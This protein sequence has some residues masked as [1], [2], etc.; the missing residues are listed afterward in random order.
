MVVGTSTRVGSNIRSRKSRVSGRASK[1][2]SLDLA[3][4]RGMA[5]PLT[6][7]FRVRSSA[8]LLNFRKRPASWRS[9]LGTQNF[10][11]DSVFGCFPGGNR[12]LSQQKPLRYAVERT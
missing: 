8:V 12:A 1:V 10:Q 6:W 7:K 11:P 4:L 9:R 3:D 5:P 2:G